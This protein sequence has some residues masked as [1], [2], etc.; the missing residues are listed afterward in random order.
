MAIPLK[1]KSLLWRYIAQIVNS[2]R[3]HPDLYLGAS[4]RASIALLNGAKAAAALQG[5]DFIRPEDVKRLTGPVLV[6]RIHLTPEREMEGARLADV[7][8]QLVDTIEVPR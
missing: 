3:N 4:P 5:R 7:V 1:W 6:H 2:T 8:Q